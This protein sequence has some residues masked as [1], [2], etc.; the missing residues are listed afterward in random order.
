MAL[1]NTNFTGHLLIAMPNLTDPYFAKSV[2]LICTHNADG[3]MGVVINRPTDMTYGL[4]FEK[5][6]LALTDIALSGR[7]VLYGGPVQPERGFVIHQAGGEWDSSIT[8]SENIALTTSKD[9]LLAVAENKGPQKLLL[10]LG[11]AG[12]VAG[13][14][15]QEIAQNA[16]LSVKPSDAPTLQKLLFETPH[17][18]QL[19]AAMALLGF[20]PSM[21]SD[22]AG[23][24]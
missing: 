15:E 7:P 24:A 17:E 22:V 8:I 14:L 16:W 23:H 1:E 9:I 21:L 19:S 12:W 6:N 3:A 10:S 18:E 5:I 11:Y 4:L 13:Q 2:T 20:D